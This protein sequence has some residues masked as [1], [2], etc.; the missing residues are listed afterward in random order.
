ME[1]RR[2]RAPG[3][4]RRR[5]RAPGMERRRGRAP[6]MERA[7]PRDGEAERASPRDGEAESRAPGM[8]RRR[9]RAP[10]MER[11][12]AEPPGW[13]GG[14]PSPRD[15]EAERASPR[16]GE[17]ERA[18]PR[19]GE[20]ER[21]SPRDGEAERAS[22]R[23]GEAERASPRDGEA[24]RASPRD[25]EAERASPRDGEAER[26]SP[27][28]GEAERASPRD[29]EAERASPRDGEAERASP[30]DGE[31]ERASPRD[32]EAERAS[33][34]DGEAERASPRDGEEPST[35]A[36]E[37]ST[38]YLIGEI[39]NKHQLQEDFNQFSQS[40]NAVSQL[41]NFQRM[42]PT[43]Q[44][45]GVQISEST[46]QGL[47]EEQRGV[48]TRLLYQIYIALRRKEK[49]QLSK[50]AMET[51]RP[52]ATA[53]LASISTKMFKER[54]HSM[55]PREVDVI[56]E[57]VSGQFVKIGKEI[58]EQARRKQEEQLQLQKTIREEQRIQHLETLHKAKKKNEEL[59]AKIQASILPVSKSV[60]RGTARAL[61]K[62]KQELRKK[63]AEMFI[64][65]INEFET[66]LKKLVPPGGEK[67]P[68]CLVQPVAT[69]VPCV[70]VDEGQAFIKI[71]RMRLKEDAL[72]R[73]KREKRRRQV[74][75]DQLEAH[76]TQ[77]EVYREEQLVNRLMRQSLQER[78][79]A[80]Q[81]MHARHEKQVMVQNRI[82]R[83]KQYE[84]KRLQ[85]FR[86][87]LDYLA[88]CD[89]TT[90]LHFQTIV[91]SYST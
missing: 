72:A 46:V 44:L 61:Q 11:R 1:R 84:E 58:E 28:D 71:V 86:E 10:G 65:E 69:F 8:E 66:I 83:E 35:F 38:G 20:A 76:E 77:E 9:G 34:R 73:K 26:A 49:A 68:E 4:E 37:F 89:V 27:R 52:L 91:Q 6:G 32:G 79:I 90:T 78:R 53:K 5:G 33:P 42:L 24:E 15:G 47:V 29:G 7:S 74:M 70:R 43:L 41:N 82:F 80:V 45:L 67:E 3:M 88:V 22:P 48:A 30:R 87:D 2:G 23:D 39:L 60:S 16:D 59:M 40:R 51:M 13:R 64:K 12:R 19:D 17:A 25:G 50:L 14:E 62:H 54:V 57:N 36:K 85:E 56:L 18:S 63:E 55:I 21:A 81:L 75:L 31:A